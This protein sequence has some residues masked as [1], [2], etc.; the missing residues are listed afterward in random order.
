MYPLEPISIDGTAVELD[1]LEM[2]LYIEA[3]RSLSWW[4]PK[5]GPVL[6]EKLL[7]GRE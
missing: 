7:E 2:S 1:Q 3:V 5:Y 6:D 4:R